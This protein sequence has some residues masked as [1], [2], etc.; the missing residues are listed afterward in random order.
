MT[1]VKMNQRD[2]E[3]RNC[4]VLVTGGAGAIG[5]NL[6][7]KL[8][9]IGAAKVIILDDLSAAYEWNIP[10]LPNV[11]FVKGSITSDID[12]KRVFCE[13]PTYIFHL[14]AFF[15]NQNSVDYPEQDLLV[16]Q[17]GTIKVLEYAVLSGNIK[18]FVY[19]G[20]GCAIYGAQAPLPLKEE[21]I[22]MN[23]STPYQIS[24]MAGELYCNFYHHHYG[25][26]IVKTRF[27]NSYGP[28][29]VPGQ[30]RNVIPNFIY[31]AM[32]GQ[33][34][35][36]TGNGRMTRDF[37]HVADIVDAL[38]LAGYS[39]RAIGEEMNIASGQEMEIMQMAEMV[40]ALTDNKAG[41]VHRDR[42]KWDTKSRLR[43]SI[44]KAKDLLGYAPRMTFEDGLQDTIRWFED[45]WEEINRDAEFPPGM[46]SAVRHH[47]LQQ[48]EQ[49]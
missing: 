1:S 28:G 20:S 42:R 14:A 35:P 5:S 7:R 25:L 16:S 18:R 24:K 11:L 48:K 44:D 31:W 29:E 40:N 30:Y 41:C 49:A 46:S 12:L 32:K 8:A 22:S 17:L 39:E 21:F 3:Y 23:L 36:I 47:V 26:P 9:E 45:H 10:N 38:L 43:A 37:T 34:L 19:A 33:P 4:T 2:E 15:A 6:S 13:K 27:F